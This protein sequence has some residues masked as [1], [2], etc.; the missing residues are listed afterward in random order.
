MNILFQGKIIEVVQEGKR[1]YAR[2]SPGTRLLI[3]KDKKILLTKE[4]REEVKGYDYRLPGGKVF[5]TLVT[6]NKFI[7]TGNNVLPIA[8]E[9]AKKE[10]R[11]EV[12]IV[13]TETK[14]IYTSVCG[15]T[16]V[17]DLFYFVVSKFEELPTQ[18]LEDG[19]DISPEWF[20]FEEAKQMALSGKMSE[21]R[22]VAVLL[23]FLQSNT[24]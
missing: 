2:R 24:S 23:R 16:V 20:T 5:D 6:Y 7:E 19:E 10:A 4:F 12:G 11:E 17:W 14:H 22:S 8:M 9:A 21:D 18:S 3:I 1:E 13:P 15:A